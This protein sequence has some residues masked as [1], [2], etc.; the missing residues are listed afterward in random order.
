MT[1]TDMI[2]MMGN[3]SMNGNNYLRDLFDY[4]GAYCDHLMS[5]VSPINIRFNKVARTGVEPAR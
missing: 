3:I 2:D 5:V 4:R 1:S